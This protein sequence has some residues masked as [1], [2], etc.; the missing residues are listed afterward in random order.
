MCEQAVQ[1][2]EHFSYLPW[3]TIG[4]R[5]QN[6]LLHRHDKTMATNWKMRWKPQTEGFH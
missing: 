5:K 2:Q 4:R 3:Q 6:C 1:F